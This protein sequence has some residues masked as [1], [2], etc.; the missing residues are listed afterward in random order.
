[1]AEW[2]AQLAPLHRDSAIRQAVKSAGIREIPS[3]AEL[4][5]AEN[6]APAIWEISHY[7]EKHPPAT[8]E[9][10]RRRALELLASVGWREKQAHVSRKNLNFFARIDAEQEL[11]RAHC[12]GGKP[13]FYLANAERYHA[14]QAIR[15]KFGRVVDELRT[16]LDSLTDVIPHARLASLPED[17]LRE[18]AE[19][20]AKFARTEHAE[21]CQIYRLA[22]LPA[23]RPTPAELRAQ[24]PY[25]HR[26]DIRRTAGLARQHLASAL[27][28][29]GRGGANYADS[30]S[31]A[32]RRERDK[33]AEIWAESRELMTADGNRIPLSDVIQ[34]AREGQGYRLGAISAGLDEYASEQGLMPIAITM[35][36]P[37]CWH[38]NP[39][40]GRRTWTPDRDPKSTDDALRALWVKFRAR[41]AKSGIRILGLR[42][43]EPHRDG[44]P[45]LHALLYIRAEQIP[46][47]D[48]HLL[49]LCPDAGA[50]RV[51][52]KLV[53]IDTTRSRGA[54]YISK[55][56][57]KTL[58]TRITADDTNEHDDDDHL[59]ADN[60]DRVRAVASERGWRRFAFLGIHGIARIW[61]RL[62]SATA[63]E[64]DGAPD[65]VATSWAH[66][67]AK[68]YREALESMGA[69]APRGAHRIRVGYATEET[70]EEGNRFP[71]L[72][73]YGEPT[74]RAYCLYDSEFPRDHP[75]HWFLKLSRGSEIVE[76]S[77]ENNEL[78][79]VSVSYP[80]AEPAAPHK[81]EEK[82]T[83]ERLVNKLAFFD[84]F[85]QAIRGYKYKQAPPNRAVDQ[86]MAL[87]NEENKQEK[88]E[89]CG[90]F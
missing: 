4:E 1:V 54:T 84:Q 11:D 53:A 68:N 48:R 64:I 33:S 30:Y 50:E 60:F 73:A 7:T 57:R 8:R 89:L 13:I 49:E 45:H 28:T 25:W 43:W 77:I 79:T 59:T 82:K 24:D 2:L 83:E 36:L 38:P 20:R 12:D 16:L 46:E 31:L 47:V 67:K 40:H 52:S 62:N 39:S 58:N 42:V 19:Q 29:V 55:Y 15:H 18:E 5:I 81:E 66:L 72:N 70:D 56:L 63:E 87:K 23:P 37:A 80:S 44:C 35:T 6:P 88:A 34:S 22:G 26:R 65:R 3:L 85:R 75:E 78:V 51:A 14:E 9:N 27:G 21:R 76:K 69:F 86:F 17:E 74:K 90:F 32:R 10:I 41:L 71:I 61:Q